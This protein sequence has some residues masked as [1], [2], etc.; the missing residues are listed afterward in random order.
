MRHQHI[1]FDLD[2]TLIDTENAVL[3]SWQLTASDFG[4]TRTAEQCRGALGVSNET[5]LERLGITD[6]GSFTGRWV[7][8]YAELA[9]STHWFEG[10]EEMLDDL[11]GVGFTLGIVTSRDALEMDLFF[12][13]YDL[14]SRFGT[15]VIADDT[16]LR[17]KPLPDPLLL[18]C[19]RTGTSPR[20]CIYIGDAPGDAEAARSAGMDFAL[21]DF[22]AS[23]APCA[24]VV[25][26]F[27]SPAALKR[28]LLEA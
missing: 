11:S 1:V 6:D 23:H 19:E 21:V 24:E 17:C 8:H 7:E 25:S 15:I 10:V 13:Q 18:Y 26:L 4:L 5:G 3:R 12:S 16:P 14:P 27:Q 22:S 2:G 28:Y 9:P 20:D